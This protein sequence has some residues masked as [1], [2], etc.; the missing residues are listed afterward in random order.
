MSFAP[1]ERRPSGA[2]RPGE[3]FSLDASTGLVFRLVGRRDGSTATSSVI[4]AARGVRNKR[5]RYDLSWLRATTPPPA[6]GGP[7]VVIT[8]LFAGCGGLSLGAAE[9]CRALGL[10]AEHAL[11]VELDDNA[12]AVFAKNFPHSDLRTRPIEELVDGEVGERVTARERR[13]RSDVGDIDL[14]IAGPPCQGHSDLNNHSRRDD[15]KN[16]LYLRALRFAEVM[17]PEHLIIENVPGVAHDR[18]GVVR[19]TTDV[20]A[21]LGYAVETAVLNADDF[22]VPQRRRRHV[23]VASRSVASPTDGLTSLHA[24]ARP[25]TWAI[26]DLNVVPLGDAF[27]T[28]ARHAAVNV[29]RIKYLFDNDL[30]ELPDAER[31]DCHRLKPHSYLAVYGRMHPDRPAPTI[32]AGFG[33]TG[34]GRFVHPSEPRTL[35]PHE[36]ARV[37][38][39]PDFFDFSA[40]RGRRALQQMIGNAVPPRLAYALAVTLLR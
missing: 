31:P 32:T 4:D 37:Q 1:P 24:P 15:P 2:V 3:S 14:L 25:V 21:R 38:G 19:T 18:L 7:P 20:L 28:P 5:D 11:A 23:L 6:E 29:N 30:Y 39:F 9:A 8:D 12:A 10:Q 26:D 36:A 16:A 40:C 22:G 33:S 35:T 17:R 34:Q 27:D 13:L